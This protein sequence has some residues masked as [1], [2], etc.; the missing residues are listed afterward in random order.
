MPNQKPVANSVFTTL[1][2]TI[3]ESTIFNDVTIELVWDPPWT[4][5]RMSDA[6]KL[7]LNLL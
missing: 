6:A 3:K 5:D 1:Q 4:M 7:Q 2:N